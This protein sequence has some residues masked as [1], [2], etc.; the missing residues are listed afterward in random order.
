M[1][2]NEAVAKIKTE[3]HRFVR[4]QTTWFRKMD[5]IHWYDMDDDPMAQIV[6]DDP[7]VHCIRVQ[8]L[9]NL[10]QANFFRHCNANGDRL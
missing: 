3:T 1:S 9:I 5:N 4:H 8:K 10:L 7:D 6:G 2:L